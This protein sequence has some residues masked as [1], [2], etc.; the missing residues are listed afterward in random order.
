MS[1]KAQFKVVSQD[2]YAHKIRVAKTRMPY[3]K[4]TAGCLMCKEKKVKCD[5]GR[6]VCARC[7]RNHRQCT[8]TQALTISRPHVRSGQYIKPSISVLS[9]ETIVPFSAP[10]VRNGTPGFHL[11]QHLQANWDAILQ[12][13]QGDEIISLF[14]CNELVRST[15]LA[16]TACHLRHLSPGVVHH[17]VA[18]CFQQS[19]ALREY[20]SILDNRQQVMAQSDVNVFLLS[21]V[22][23]NILALALPESD[24]AEPSRSWVLSPNEDRLGWLALQ[25]GLRPLMSSLAVEEENLVR[26]LS[27]LSR[28]FLGGEKDVWARVQQILDPQAVPERWNLIFGLNKSSG[29]EGEEVNRDEVFRVPVMV[30]TRLR[31]LEPVRLNALKNFAFLAKMKSSFRELLYN[32]D[33]RALWI[34]GY[35]LGVMQRFQGLWWCEKRVKR[36]YEAILSWLKHL[37]LDERPGTEGQLW[38]EM[39]AEIE[40]APF[41]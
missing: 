5:E 12:I 40:L 7:R 19:L 23:L 24:D 28:I 37:R 18:E 11:M 30:L 21:A 16:I 10:S 20:Q 15:I 9:A 35:W 39:M 26:L 14:R 38:A 8:Y 41:Y 32:K 22:L 6:P 2:D 36:D 29:Q 17:R 13:P 25:A 1:S 33:E 34:F 3:T 4:T 27:F 31:D